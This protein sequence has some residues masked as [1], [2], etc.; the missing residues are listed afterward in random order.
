MPTPPAGCTGAG[1]TPS[2]PADCR[3]AVFPPSLPAALAGFTPPC[4]PHASPD[5][6]IAA[7]TSLVIR[8][9]PPHFIEG[10]SVIFPIA[11]NPIDVRRIR[12]PQLRPPHA[13]LAAADR[14]PAQRRGGE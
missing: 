3:G 7:T 9:E 10:R 2:P 4:P 8:I 14:V 6:A 12:R 5:T 1:C 11:Y 13:Q